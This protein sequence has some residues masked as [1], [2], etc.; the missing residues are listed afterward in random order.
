MSRDCDRTIGPKTA[1]K[2]YGGASARCSAL[3][4]PDRP[5]DSLAFTLPP[6]TIS[7]FNATW[8]LMQ[9]H[10]V[11]ARMVCSDGTPRWD[12]DLVDHSARAVQL[13]SSLPPG[14][15]VWLA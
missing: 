8:S 2:R 12:G 3:S 10:F 15:R 4:Q 11:K 6:A 1:T 13:T 7:T 5:S 9:S 14:A